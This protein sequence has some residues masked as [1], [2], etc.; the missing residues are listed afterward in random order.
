[1]IL[2]FNFSKINS[3][4]YN[5]LPITNSHCAFQEQTAWHNNAEEKKLEKRFHSSLLVKIARVHYA[6]TGSQM[7]LSEI[8][9]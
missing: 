5:F 8:L 9:Q 2:M 6:V 4:S 1:M 3:S 7:E